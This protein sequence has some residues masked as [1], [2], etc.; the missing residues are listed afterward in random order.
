MK[1][2]IV[3]LSL[4]LLLLV[5]GF[6]VGA[7]AAGQPMPPDQSNF[8]LFGPAGISYWCSAVLN[9]FGEVWIYYNQLT[10]GPN[11]ETVLT[12]LPEKEFCLTTGVKEI[13]AYSNFV[14]VLRE[15]GTLEYWR[16]RLEDHNLLHT[17]RTD[18]VD[19]ATSGS[20][21]I[22]ALTEQ[23]D[24]YTCDGYY[25]EN[26]PV[27]K[28][29]SGVAALISA[30]SYVREDG[31]AMRYALEELKVSATGLPDDVVRGWQNGGTYY[32]LTRDGELWG[33][34]DNNY[35]QLGSGTYN[36][37]GTYFYFGS[38]TDGVRTV[39]L[40]ST[41][42][43][44]ILDDVVRIWLDGYQVY[45]LMEDGS[46]QTWGDG[47]P[48]T[49]YMSEV[50]GWL[51][52]G[53][54]QYPQGW[55]NCKGWTPREIT[56]SQWTGSIEG[57]YPAT[58]YSDGSV[59]ADH[60]GARQY[61][62]RWFGRPEKPIYTD[63]PLNA[64]YA[65]PVR[66]AVEKKV[67]S[68]TGSTT[69]SPNATCTQAQI[70]TFLWRAAGSPEP[71]GPNDFSNAAVTAGQ[72]YYEALLW[73]YENGVVDDPDLDPDGPCT[74]SDVVTYLWKLDGSPAAESESVFTDVS[75]AA[76]YAAAVQWAVKNAI[77]TGTSA[78]TFTPAATCTRGEIVTFLYHYFGGE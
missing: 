5:P 59:W 33:W 58:F 11:G 66:W 23:G 43:V 48:V 71:A 63:V 76:P 1:K 7:Q 6:S 72:Y 78:T 14:F 53:E 37:T 47:E 64:Y 35:G 41:N 27:E 55:P 52:E 60:S 16:F 75:S 49:A 22:L 32:V 31:T 68:G 15:N 50:D 3:A 61:V 44:K 30:S 77:T 19:I 26:V 10:S 42:P 4:C 40:Q 8:T 67:T 21:N 17:L 20:Y 69:F 56:V 45:A 25:Y 62:G 13:A 36:G 38:F 51:Q 46:Y 39:R 9:E 54:W 74:R 65:Q 28:I 70:L 73:A 29:D 12:Y 34:G 57:L 2:R 18:V 24:L